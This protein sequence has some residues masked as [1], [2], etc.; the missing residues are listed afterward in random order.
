MIRVGDESWTPKWSSMSKL[1][2]LGAGRQ[3]GSV[4]PRAVTNAKGGRRVPS[5]SWFASDGQAV[6]PPCAGWA[7]IG[8]VRN[9]MVS[10]SEPAEPPAAAPSVPVRA[11]RWDGWVPTELRAVAPN[12]SGPAGPWASGL[13][14]DAALP[15]GASM[16]AA[17]SCAASRADSPVPVTAPACGAPASGSP[18]SEWCSAEPGRPS[19]VAARRSCASACA[20]E[21]PVSA[22]GPSASGAARLS[23]ARLLAVW[24]RRACPPVDASTRAAWTEWPGD[25]SAASPP[26]A[27]GAAHSARS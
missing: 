15:A 7:W 18:G 1:W 12:G 26:L 11:A 22:V 2:S 20:P 5:P 6:S 14:S 27:P 9:A 25:R 10:G 3:S 8:L 23:P 4:Q 13:G 17:S 24:S 19:R 16:A 21:G